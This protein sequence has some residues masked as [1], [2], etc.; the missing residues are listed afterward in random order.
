MV[1]IVIP[2]HRPDFSSPQFFLLRVEQNGPKTVERGQVLCFE[3]EFC[4][5]EAV[6]ELE[7]GIHIYDE[8]GRLA[9]S[10]SSTLLELPLVQVA[11]GTHRVSYYLVADL[12][13]G[14]YS[15]GFSFVEP[16]AE[17]LRELA[18]YDQLVTFR[19]T[20]PRLRPGSGYVS[21]PVEFDCRQMNDTIFGLVENAA[22][23]I[24][25][26]AVL[27]DV[28]VEE[29][30]I[31]PVRLHNASD[32]T[33]VNTICNPIN[34]SY[35]WLD[36]E[37]NA[38]VVDGNRTHLPVLAVLPGQ[39]ITTQMDVVAPGR[40]GRY[41][42]VLVP[43]Q[44]M[45]CW[46]DQRGFTTTVLEMAVIAKEST[47]RYLGAD[48]RLFSMIGRRDNSV[49]E[50]TG[51]KG[52]LFIGA[53]AQLPAGRY[54]VQLFGLCEPRGAGVW[55]DVVRDEG[56]NIVTRLDLSDGL[57]VGRIAELSFELIEPTSDLEVRM[58][59]TD[60]AR[61]RVE[62]I[63]I[64]QTADNKKLT[65]ST[66]EQVRIKFENA[67]NSRSTKKNK[68]KYNNLAF[69]TVEQVHTKLVNAMNSCFRK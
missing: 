48:V 27:G 36:L 62:E 5:V 41:R 28:A 20:L 31:L 23:T 9:F 40:P 69:S 54:L 55:V 44:E 39:I 3:L 66:I 2:K 53:Y 22:G 34:L 13:E 17:G 42:L 7:I 11:C 24:D 67:M 12:P 37:G 45:N 21:L 19:L 10:T 8:G 30:F 33:W 60:E 59:V 50:S 58:W 35:R 68:N 25:S 26:S 56:A 1:D 16:R 15:V 51:V 65:F 63:C 38:V 61:V 18:W 47:R 29:R 43:V 52:F 6:G 49:L 46:F 57:A 64:R 14:A 32:Q 4:L